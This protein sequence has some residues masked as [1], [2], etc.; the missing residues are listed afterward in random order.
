MLQKLLNL[1]F[2][3]SILFLA[4]ECKPLLNRFNEECNNEKECRSRNRWSTNGFKFGPDSL[5][6]KLCVTLLPIAKTVAQKNDTS[7]LAKFAYLVCE[8][9]KVE[10]K[11]VCTQV[12]ASYEVSEKKIFL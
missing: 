10:D 2:V 6:C 3:V 11:V 9:A 7:L 12:I 4:L 5:E 8:L 1:I